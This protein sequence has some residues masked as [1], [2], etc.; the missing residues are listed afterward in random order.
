VIEMAKVCN[1]FDTCDAPLC[2]LD[3]KSLRSGIWYPDESICKKKNPP[4]WVKRQKRY[5]K[6]LERKTSTSR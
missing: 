5:L 2:P 1:Y 3:E 6:K 4:E